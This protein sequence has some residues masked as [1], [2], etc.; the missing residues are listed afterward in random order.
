MPETD[1]C[2]AVASELSRLT[3]EAKDKLIRQAVIDRI[4]PDWE[5]QDVI[6]RMQCVVTHETHYRPGAGQTGLARCVPDL[7]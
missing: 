1:E 2:T 7:P 5:T 3:A 4:G 6:P